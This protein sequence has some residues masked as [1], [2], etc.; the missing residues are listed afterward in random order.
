MT[1]ILKR[2]KHR[3]AHHYSTKL[4]TT[5]QTF[6]TSKHAFEFTYSDFP[7]HFKVNRDKLVLTNRQWMCKRGQKI[8]DYRYFLGAKVRQQGKKPGRGRIVKSWT[9]HVRMI[10]QSNMRI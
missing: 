7:C 10:S 1:Q 6:T 3:I 5:K 9:S 2:E 4:Q 8:D